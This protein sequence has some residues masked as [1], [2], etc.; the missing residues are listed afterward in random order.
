MPPPPPPVA[1]LPATEQVQSGD[2]EPPPGEPEAIDAGAALPAEPPPL[3][4][5]VGADAGEGAAS[6]QLALRLD[7]DLAERTVRI[8]LDD[9]SEPVTV[10]HR[11]GRWRVRAGD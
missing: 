6:W 1:D 2:P 4:V 9:D 5:V 10:V 11:D 7:I 8:G 3:E